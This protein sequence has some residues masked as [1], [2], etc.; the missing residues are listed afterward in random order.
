MTESVLEGTID[1]PRTPGNQVADD[2][3]Y[4]TLGGHDFACRRVSISWQMMKFAVAQ[5]DANAPIPHPK[6]YEL[7]THRSACKSCSDIHKRRNDAGMTLMATMHD[8]VKIL[9][10]PDERD[11]FEDYMS[12]AELEPE[13]L[14]NAI[15]D[16]IA[17]I[18]S[19]GK[20]K[21]TSSHSS[22]QQEATPQHSRTIS[23]AQGSEAYRDAT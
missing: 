19:Q 17:R 1:A 12:T 9:L 6:D 21:G 20:A 11:R 8:A 18:G 23:F 7:E 5:R 16:A 22:A 3:V 2:T 14:E 10:R 15:G 4:L 13:E